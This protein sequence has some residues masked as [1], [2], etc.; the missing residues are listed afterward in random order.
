[1]KSAWL[2]KSIVT[3]HGTESFPF[4]AH[5][6][7]KKI[8]NFAGGCPNT[9]RGSL[10]HCERTFSRH[11]YRVFDRLNLKYVLSVLECEM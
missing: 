6:G 7:R 10:S 8:E 1:L 11:I 2:E 5:S 4:Q 9:V 3:R